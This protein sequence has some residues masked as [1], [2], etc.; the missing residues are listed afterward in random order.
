MCPCGNKLRIRSV[1]TTHPVGKKPFKAA[2]Y[3]GKTHCKEKKN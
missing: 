3:T 1:T 2:N